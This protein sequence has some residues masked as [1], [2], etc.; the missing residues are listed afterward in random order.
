MVLDN[1]TTMMAVT[2]TSLDCSI[3]PVFSS[4]CKTG[5]LV[6]VEGVI[7]RVDKEASLQWMEC[8]TCQSDK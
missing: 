7:L 1:Y 3:L 5:D 8:G 4:A 6:K 2:S